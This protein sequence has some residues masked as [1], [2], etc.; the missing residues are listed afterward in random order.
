MP[1]TFDWDNFEDI[2]IAL[3]E[4]FPELDPYTRAF[5][6]HAQMDHGTAW[7]RR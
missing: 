7:F 6:R 5:Y 3:T 4:K 2:A 1:S